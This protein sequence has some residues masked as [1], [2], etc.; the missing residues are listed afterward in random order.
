MTGKTVVTKRKKR[1]QH[2]IDAEKVRLEVDGRFVETWELLI[3]EDELTGIGDLLMVFSRYAVDGDGKLS[4]DLPDDP[5]DEL[6]DDQRQEIKQ[7]RAYK[8]LRRF[9]LPAL[10]NAASSFADQAREDFDPN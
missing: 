2:K 1:Q 8:A 7:S 5:L 4:P 10:R 6:T 9:P 3:F